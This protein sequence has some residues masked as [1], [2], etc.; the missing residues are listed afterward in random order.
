MCSHTSLLGKW[1]PGLSY[2]KMLFSSQCLGEAFD[3]NQWNGRCKVLEKSTSEMDG[4]VRRLSDGARC[5]VGLSEAHQHCGPR[6]SGI[7]GTGGNGSL[8]KPLWSIFHRRREIWTPIST[9]PAAPCSICVGRDVC[10]R[11]LQRNSQENWDNLNYFTKKREKKHAVFHSLLMFFL[12]MSSPYKQWQQCSLLLLNMYCETYLSTH[13]HI[14]ISGK[15][16]CSLCKYRRV[17]R[18]KQTKQVT[19]DTVCTEMR[20][21]DARQTG[22]NWCQTWQDEKCL[23]SSHSSSYFSRHIRTIPRGPTLVINAFMQRA[24]PTIG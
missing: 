18:N 3:S 6:S 22:R 16:L 4:D 9:C 24:E 10:G 19:A 14:H 11:L 7:V 17:C 1:H 23:W 13:T 8:L 21:V 20:L 2:T 12:C 15:D 5:H